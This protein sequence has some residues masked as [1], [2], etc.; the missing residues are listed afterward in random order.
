MKRFS[1]R[2]EGLQNV[3]GIELDNLRM[4]MRSIE[5]QLELAQLQLHE[6]QAELET[7]YEEIARLR[8]SRGGTVM[9]ESLNG[10][11]ALL[12]HRLQEQNGLIARRQH[13]LEQARLRVS[14]KHRETKVLEKHREQ[15]FGIYLQDMERDMQREM[16]ESAGNMGNQLD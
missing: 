7:S 15:Q 4:D 5:H 12:R 16:D 10:Y 8:A 1:Y 6:M 11:T 2:F 3:R 9:L 14:E 13:E